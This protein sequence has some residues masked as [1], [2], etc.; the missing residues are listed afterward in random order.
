MRKTNSKCLF[1]LFF[2]PLT[3]AYSRIFK[4]Q[5]FSEDTQDDRCYCG[6]VPN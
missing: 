3:P 6:V 1:F 5:E 2:H 4:H